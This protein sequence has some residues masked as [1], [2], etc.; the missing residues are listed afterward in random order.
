[1]SFLDPPDRQFSPRVIQIVA[2]IG[3]ASSSFTI[4]VLSAALP[5]IA[6]DL[7]SSTGT[8]T[9]VIAG[10]LLAFAVFT[11]MAGKLGDLYGHRRMYLLG[12]TAAAIMSFVTA[13][14]PNAGF[15]IG[16]RIV[17]QAFASSTGPSALAIMMRAFPDDERTSVA[18]VWSAV[19][20]ASPAIG[21]VVGGPLIDATSW[22][23]LFI[24]QGIGMAVAVVV[25]SRVLPESERRRDLTFDL[26]GGVFLAI[27][28]AAILIPLNRAGALGWD[29]PVIWGGLLLAPIALVL[30]VWWERRTPHPLIELAVLAERNVSLP[31]VSQL[32]LNGPYM[33]GLVI[34]SLMLGAD[35]TFAYNTTAISLLILPRPIMFS[36][37]AWVADRLVN[38]LGGRTV[39]IAGCVGVS[40]GLASIGLGA[41]QDWLAFVIIGVAIAGAGSGIARPPIIAAL[42]ESVGERD[43]GVGTGMLNMTGQIGAAA[44]ISLLSALVTEDS[45]PE[46]FLLVFI[47][48]SVVAILS[49]VTAGAIR[50]PEAAPASKPTP[51]PTAP[52]S[53]TIDP[54]HWRQ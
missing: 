28:I 10:P 38:R 13:A 21:V 47:I 50:F 36:L 54:R 17:T 16:A 3:V 26:L 4:T 51:S 14:S 32:F 48:A 12:F 9:W 33:A 45:S 34:T 2:L 22:R 23:T 5:D 35:S 46:R 15:L 20:A 39:V 27:G 18:G 43:M 37:G 53:S 42:T 8:I 29:H 1:M 19:L 24:V 25:S 41:T 7:D 6:D 11:P 44:G 30:F 40:L 49:I 31:L 52:Y